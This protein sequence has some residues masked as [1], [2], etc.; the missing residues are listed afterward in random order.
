MVTR[1][2]LTLVLL[3]GCCL[4]GG[5]DRFSTQFAL[6]QDEVIKPNP[7]GNWRGPNFNGSAGG[8]RPPVRWDSETNVSWKVPIP[9]S[10]S[11]SPIVWGNQVIVVTALATDEEGEPDL[12][13][14]PPGPSVSPAFKMMRSR[15]NHPLPKTLYQFMVMSFDR[16]SGAVLWKTTVKKAVPHEGGHTTNT[17]A[18]GSP[19]TD[20][21]RIFVSFGSYGVHCLNMQGRL[22]WS[23]D[24]GRMTTRNNFGEASSPAL[25][26][27][28]LVVP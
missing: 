1:K 20:G 8:A 7:W 17:Y 6:G 19:V 28:T 16:E 22:L 4:T 2:I 14:V 13:G 27:E 26:S 25:F 10:G 23:V 15:M 24:L 3:I 12:T 9:G 5:T 18:S 21:E 11:G